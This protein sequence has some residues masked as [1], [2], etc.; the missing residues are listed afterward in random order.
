MSVADVFLTLWNN[1]V[2]GIP[3]F[4]YAVVWLIV[5]F[6]IGQV[7]YKVAKEILVRVKIDDYVAEKER[8]KIKLSDAFSMISKWVIYLIFI[9]VAAESLQVATLIAVT[10]STINFLFGAVA[11][12]ILI[13]V[14]YSFAVYVKDKVLS[15]KTLYGDLVGQ[16]IFFLILY[17]SIALALPFLRIDTTIINWILLAIVGSIGVG[18]AIALGFGLRDVV[19]DLAKDYVR[20]ARVKK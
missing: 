8:L 9:Q 6:I 3:G 14:G 18:L 11:A 19:A 1:F 16:V 5:G 17:V 10:N 15:S 4:I 7:V 13:I 2:A 12:T 20:K